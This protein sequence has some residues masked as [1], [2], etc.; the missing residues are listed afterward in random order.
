LIVPVTVLCEVDDFISKYLGDHVARRFMTGQGRNEW[1]LLGFEASDLERANEIRA[2]YAER[3]GFVG[4][5]ESRTEV[6]FGVGIPLILTVNSGP[7]FVGGVLGKAGL[8][9]RFSSIFSVFAEAGVG[10]IFEGGPG[11]VL[12]DVAAGFNFRF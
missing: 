2:E 11:T 10:Y 3:I 4:A 1:T 5:D 7:A 8:E 9:F 12:A 6:Y